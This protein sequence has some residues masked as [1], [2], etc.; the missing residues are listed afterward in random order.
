MNSIYKTFCGWLHLFLLFFDLENPNTTASES[1]N[2]F[3]EGVSVVFEYLITPDKGYVFERGMP[4]QKPRYNPPIQTLFVKKKLISI[5]FKIFY[6]ILSNYATH[7][8]KSR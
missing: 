7:F 8:L 6:W 4:V 2:K 3:S 1:F 5:D